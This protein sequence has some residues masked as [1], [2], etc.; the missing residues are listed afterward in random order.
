LPHPFRSRVAGEWNYFVKLRVKNI[1]ELEAFLTA[2]LK[3][4]P[5]VQQTNAMIVLSSIKETWAVALT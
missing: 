4:I 2:I 1:P 3:S 5:G